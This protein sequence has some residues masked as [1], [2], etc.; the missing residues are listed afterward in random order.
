MSRDKAAAYFG[1]IG[2]PI[3]PNINPADFVIDVLLDPNRAH[4]TT[5]DISNLDF[6]QS[7]QKSVLLEK[8]EADIQLS[9]SNFPS[10]IALGDVRPFATSTWKQFCQ[11]ALRHGRTVMRDPL[12]S[13]VALVQVGEIS[14]L[15]FCFLCLNSTPK[16]L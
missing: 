2:F 10:L 9:K 12:S 6:A 16:R 5:K 15:H 3:P 4:F 14:R 13:F 1:S 11:L 7:Y 8:S